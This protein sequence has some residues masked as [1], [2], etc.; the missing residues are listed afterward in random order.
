MTTPSR[1]R[2]RRHLRTPHPNPPP[3]AG[4]RRTAF[5]VPRLAAVV[6]GV[7]MLTNCAVIPPPSR[8]T[9]TIVLDAIQPPAGVSAATWS[10]FH[11]ITALCAGWAATADASAA[12]HRGRLQRGAMVSTVAGVLAG[13]AGV[14]TGIY[15]AS[16]DRDGDKDRAIRDAKIGGI[17][18]FG[19]GLLATGGGFYTGAQAGRTGRASGI[20]VELERAVTRHALPMLLDS[21]QANRDGTLAREGIALAIECARLARGL[22]ELDE[23]PA[24]G[25]GGPEIDNVARI[26]R[27]APSEAIAAGQLARE[28]FPVGATP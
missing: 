13:A 15:A 14:T 17:V 12:R 23:L 2:H 10:G 1:A 16:A 21:G 4:G 5:A 22:D 8:P 18:S 28:V 25:T 26:L 27:E 3:Y 9:A 20:A 6:L 24:P 19:L 11:A 7:S